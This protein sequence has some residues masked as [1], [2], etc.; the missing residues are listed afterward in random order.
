MG[1]G[2]PL[3]RCTWVKGASLFM[4][5]KLRSLRLTLWILGLS[6]A[7]SYQAAA[8]S[9]AINPPSDKQPSSDPTPTEPPAAESKQDEA[10]PLAVDTEAAR[11]AARE[12]ELNDLKE[13][14]AREAARKRGEYTFDDL[15]FDIE[16]GGRF[17]EEM[18]SDSVKELNKKTMRIRGYILPDSVMQT[19]GIKR[20]VLVRDN[21]ECC[22]GPG[23][24]LYDCIVVEMEEGKTA[25]FATRPVTVKGSFEIDSKS[26]QYPDDGGHYAI[27][28][29]K[30]VEVK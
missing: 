3:R 8:T 16:R 24:M 23:A 15:K 5:A 20:F 26:F 11:E 10:Q 2:D 25:T 28:K 1:I 17:H 9:L 13:K 19:S 18:L 27:F 30:A 21:K 22:F 14:K 4:F 29:L 7:T 6:L 12:A